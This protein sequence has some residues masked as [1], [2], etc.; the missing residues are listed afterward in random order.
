MCELTF[1]NEFPEGYRKDVTFEVGYFKDN[2]W[3]PFIQYQ[4]IRPNYKKLQGDKLSPVNAISIPLE[5][6]AET[7]LVFAEAQI[8]ASGNPSD[9]D[10]LMPKGS[11]K[12]LLP[13]PNI[14]TDV[15]PNL[16]D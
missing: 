11:I 3:I 2:G 4:T 16:L 12:Y 8:M 13:L 10:E 6:F 9:T 7:Y 5:R 14:E 1:F 15:N